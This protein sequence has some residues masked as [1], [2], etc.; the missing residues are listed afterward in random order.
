ML[1]RKS[2][3]RLSCQRPGIIVPGPVL[4]AFPRPSWP[5]SDNPM[6]IRRATNRAN[7]KLGSVS[8]VDSAGLWAILG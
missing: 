3:R 8:Q 2:Q 1:R 6:T 7:R 4:R 5:C